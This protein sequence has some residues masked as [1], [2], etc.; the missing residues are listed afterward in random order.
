VHDAT[1]LAFGQI[2]P[3][4]ALVVQL[5]RADMAAIARTVSPAVVRIVWPTQ[6]TV[7]DP[8]TYADA[9]STAMKVLA[10]ASVELSSIR[11]RTQGIL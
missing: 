4:D 1:Q 10:G 2:T 9:A 5:I 6:P 8:R 11:A 3:T 7:V